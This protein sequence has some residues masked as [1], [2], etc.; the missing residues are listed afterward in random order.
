MLL[1]R[2]RN[3]ADFPDTRHDRD[4]PRRGCPVARVYLFSRPISATLQLVKIL[5]RRRSV[6]RI[7]LDTARARART[8]R[9]DKAPPSALH[10]ALSRYV[11]KSARKIAEGT[12]ISPLFVENRRGE[13]QIARAARQRASGSISDLIR[14]AIF[15]LARAKLHK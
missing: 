10:I 13:M 5:S 8:I 4:T 12:R 3:A 11:T 15:V 14:I 6:R 1:A 9:F 7:L 2:S